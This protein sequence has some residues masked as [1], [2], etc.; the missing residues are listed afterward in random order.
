MARR[1][2]L[3]TAARYARRLFED[4]YVHGQ[5]SDAIS[6]LR[7]VYGRARRQPR[8]R[9]A[10]DKK[11]YSNLREAAASLRK[12]ANA[13]R[14]ESKPR[15]RGRRL[16]LVIGLGGAAGLL[17]SDVLRRAA[18]LG[19][20]LSEGC[21]A[22]CADP[23]ERVPGR[24]IAL[25]SSE[26]PGALAQAVDGRVYALLPGSLQDARR[27]A[28][29]IGHSA[30]VGISSYYANPGQVRQ[31]LEEAELVLSVTAVR[32]RPPSEDIGGGSYRLLFRVLA[33]HP[34][35]VRS[36]YEDTIAPLVRYDQQ[37]STD[38]LGTLE[39]YLAQ[40]CS[41]N[42]TAATIHAH[43][44]TVSYRLERVRELTG[45][46]PFTSED[47]ERL[48]LGLKAQRILAPRLPR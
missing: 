23:G 25:I 3:K 5:L 19:C 7:R 12:A 34:E 48:S 13:V 29:R 4:E 9:A 28:S 14:R 41:M 42:A 8:S 35:E 10:E 31:A 33:S 2:R 47:R 21:V 45:L 43:R 32:G 27:L 37:Y 1:D 40:N 15:R 22:L 20:D 11:I 36:F 39:A 6:R 18:R 24:L 17:A 30:L 16:F 38:M 26:Q 44:H 46:D